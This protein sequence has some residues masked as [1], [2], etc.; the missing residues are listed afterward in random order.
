[1]LEP[2]PCHLFIIEAGSSNLNMILPIFLDQF[3][4]AWGSVNVW[5][6]VPTNSHL[7]LAVFHFPAVVIELSADKGHIWLA[8]CCWFTGIASEMEKQTM[9]IIQSLH[10][11]FTRGK[12]IIFLY[13]A[14]SRNLIVMVI[15][16]VTK[17]MSLIY[18]IMSVKW[19]LVCRR[20]STCRMQWSFL[21]HQ[22]RQVP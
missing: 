19:F 6:L 10:S 8:R 22:T 17:H 12:S 5:L 16:S 15:I 2:I 11:F 20:G 13:V 14:K 21:S 9:R 1:M 3:W 7:P 18:K 4:A